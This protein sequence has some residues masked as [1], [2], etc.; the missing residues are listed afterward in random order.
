MVLLSFEVGLHLHQITC[1]HQRAYLYYNCTTGTDK[2]VIS[3][4]KYIVQTIRK[5]ASKKMR[6]QKKG[7]IPHSHTPQELWLAYI[8]NG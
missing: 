8:S 2:A 3:N 5:M 1:V 6:M 4:D 7:E